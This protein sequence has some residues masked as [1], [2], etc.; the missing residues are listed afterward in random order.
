MNQVTSIGTHL[1]HR[2]GLSDDDGYLKCSNCNWSI[3]DQEFKD[4]EYRIRV[5]NKMDNHEIIEVKGELVIPS[6]ESKY[7]LSE[8]ITIPTSLLDAVVKGIQNNPASQEAIKASKEV[9]ELFKVV[10]RPDLQEGIDSGKLIWDGCS[11]E[12]R[13]AKTKWYAG[14]IKLEK[15]ELPTK[16][17]KSNP[18][19]V[20]MTLSNV[21]NAICSLSGQLQLAEI[22]KKID[23]LDDKINSL[24]ENS[25]R[26][27]IAALQSATETINDARIGLPD[28][29]A[30]AR[31]N[32][33]IIEVGELA[34][35]FRL[36][37]ESILSKKITFSVWSSFKESLL[38]WFGKNKDEYN[39]E[40]IEQ[41]KELLDEYSFLIDCYIQSETLRGICYQVI[42]EYENAKKYYGRV[43]QLVSYSSHELYKKLVFLCDINDEDSDAH[44]KIIDVLPLIDKRQIPIK[45]AI[46]TANDNGI[47]GINKTLQIK[48]QLL[49][50]SVIT[51]ELPREILLLQ[52]D[53]GE[54]YEC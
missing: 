48:Q 52:N 51:F 37:I 40:F 21:T 23:I 39:K 47:I 5:N 46:K 17:G 27:K 53:G 19:N 35:Y 49:G 45:E 20:I 22:S 18:S 3:T 42:G 34:N 11:V 43:E 31:I 8:P 28:R 24:I 41:L 16:V 50:G 7:E 10:L 25:W 14:K 38:S 12:I 15:V 4:N 1:E 29:N 32:S 36:T 44:K 54:S 2:S 33:A 6:T 26:E 30:L 13:D 9:A